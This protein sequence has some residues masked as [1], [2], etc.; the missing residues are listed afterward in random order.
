M[1]KLAKILAAAAMVLGI[2]VSAWAMGKVHEGTV[3]DTMD[4]GGYTYVQVKEGDNTFWAAGP[5]VKVD[6]G[7]KVQVVEQMW[8]T[9]FTSKTLKRTFDKLMFVGEIAKK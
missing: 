8:M 9:N 1:V 7:D 6:K 5:Q 4:S 2:S 3:L